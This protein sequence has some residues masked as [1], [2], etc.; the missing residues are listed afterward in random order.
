M[1]GKDGG[2]REKGEKYVECPIANHVP[3]A[4]GCL[5]EARRRRVVRSITLVTP[6]ISSR[7]IGKEDL[8]RN[9]RGT[10]GE[11]QDK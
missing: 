9:T 6:T 3:T 5:R 11:G 8:M 1:V 7:K 2:G 4:T 10:R